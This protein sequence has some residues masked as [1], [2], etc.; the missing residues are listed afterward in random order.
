[1]RRSRLL[2][3][4]AVL[5]LAIAGALG[6]AWWYAVRCVGEWEG[7]PLEVRMRGDL[8]GLEAAIRAD[9]EHLSVTIGERN[10]RDA[11]RAR[12]LEAAGAFVRR[13]LEGLG[14]AVREQ[15]LVVEGHAVSNLEVEVPGAQSPSEIVI[16]SA[17]HDSLPESP[18]ANNNASGEAVLL[19]IAALL[20]GHAP[21]RTLR[22]VS[23]TTE[24][25]PW[26]GT[27][28]MGSRAYA[29]RCRERGE[30]VV[31]MLSL[32]SLGFY[33]HE[34]G[35]QR[36]PFPFS[37]FYPDRGDFLAFIG[38]LGSRA[39]VVAATRGFRKGSAFPIAG[40]AAPRSVE[41]VSWSDHSSFWLHGY[42][43][44]QVTDTGGFRSP[45]H[46]TR[47]DT[48]EKLDFGALARIAVGLRGSVMELTTIPPGDGAP[49]ARA[50]ARLLSLHGT[51]VLLAGLLCGFPFYVSIVRSAP[52]DRAR[53]WRVAHA[54]LV[55]GGV[56]LLVAAILVP[57]LALEPSLLRTLAT[58]FVASGYG[59]VLALAGGACVGRR[60]L[61][62][63]PFGLETL[64]FAGHVAGALGA[65]AGTAL[66]LCG[67][68]AR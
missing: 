49:P 62:P 24:E 39:T 26:F 53:A 19:A 20:R 11:E 36:L 15:P 14:Y 57:R 8:P 65:L 51:L 40:G 23:F 29:H 9:V 28:R 25:D 1:M 46:T 45:F 31:A 18:G 47:G 5:G 48:A 42:Q 63:R 59:F 56:L 54:T 41:G 44:I 34:P 37:L 64:L 17:Q 2:A 21:G 43:G 16:V 4:G 27:E 12:A 52:P 58:S 22:F 30:D 7:E 38:D 66:L 68:A 6:F 13:R 33:A 35:S 60:G 61:L 67:A 32:D 10:L 50:A 3:A 55:A